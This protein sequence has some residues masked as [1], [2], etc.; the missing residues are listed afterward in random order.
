MLTDRLR[1]AVE[2][3]YASGDDPSTTDKNEGWDELY[4]TAHKWLGLADVFTQGPVKRTNVA[5]GVL[6]LTGKATKDLT[7]QADGHLF[8]R[9]EK[10]GGQ[11]G[12]AG[13][14]VDVGVAYAL[15]K[16][17]KVRG[18]YAVYLAN[19]DFYPVAPATGEADPI[20]FGELEL[21]YDLM[22]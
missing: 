2:G 5:S 4:P 18:L 21:R 8:S 20:H 11:E 3:I 12:F 17:L 15:A 22:P 19:S 13:A 14:E 10:V 9:L 1:V 16:G 7:V 6:H